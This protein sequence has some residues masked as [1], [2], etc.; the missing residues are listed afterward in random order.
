MHEKQ[1]CHRRK[2]PTATRS[3]GQ[4]ECTNTGPLP[5][6]I[7]RQLAGG[8]EIINEWLIMVP[9]PRPRM[10]CLSYRPYAEHCFALAQKCRERCAARWLRLLSIDLAAA[11]DQWRRLSHP[12]K[13]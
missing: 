8:K 12:Q 3:Q 10:R 4:S 2:K 5:G 9:F 1:R 7:V 13:R 11:A 6:S